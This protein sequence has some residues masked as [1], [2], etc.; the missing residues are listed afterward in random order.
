MVLQGLYH[1]GVLIEA[2]LEREPMLTDPLR[3]VIDLELAL[4]LPIDLGGRGLRMVHTLTPIDI[5]L[6]EEAHDQAREAVL[7]VKFDTL[8]ALVEAEPRVL[9]DERFELCVD[10]GIHDF[11]V[12]VLDLVDVLILFSFLVLRRHPDWEW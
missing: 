3:V 12:L 6:A 5:E 4:A 7:L 9:F 11:D 1:I 10:Q 2:L 8:G